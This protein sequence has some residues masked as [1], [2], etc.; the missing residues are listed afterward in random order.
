MSTTYHSDRTYMPT[1]TTPNTVVNEFCKIQLS[2]FAINLGLEYGT[3]LKLRLFAPKNVPEAVRLKRGLSFKAKGKVVPLAK[4]GVI[5]PITRHP[6]RPLDIKVQKHGKEGIGLVCD[7]NNF[8][9]HYAKGFNAYAV[10]NDIPEEHIDKS[11]GSDDDVIACRALFYECD[12]ISI[13]AQWA[14]L[15]ELEEALGRKATMIVK[16]FKSLHC[17]FTLEVPCSKDEWTFFQQRLIQKMGSDSSLWNPARI[18][19]LPG[20]PYRKF[21]DG[22]IKDL[23]LVEIA[24]ESGNRFA[25]AEFEGVLPEWDRG[26][27]ER[28]VK[29]HNKSAARSSL[30]GQIDV[31]MPENMQPFDMRLLAPYLPDYVEGGR[32]GW[33]T[34]RCPVH[35]LEG[36]HSGDSLHINRETGAYVCHAGCSRQDVWKATQLNALTAGYSPKPP[37]KWRSLPFEPDYVCNSRHFPSDLQMPTQPLVAVL[38]AIRFS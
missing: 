36:E 34:A 17:Y 12:D 24:E 15:R 22:D 16:T 11:T 28:V 33:D 3:P 2:K 23:Q 4:H 21:E 29:K 37:N 38:G 18:M 7:H 5:Y 26:K 20:F 10:I 13:E 25:L 6:R 31:P 32:K 35:A 19:R 30:K 8:E 14:K 9:H 1:I 27:W